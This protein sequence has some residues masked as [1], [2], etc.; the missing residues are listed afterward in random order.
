MSGGKK[1]TVVQVNRS[2]TKVSL[3]DVEEEV[4]EENATR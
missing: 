4:E 1:V 3:S 2:L